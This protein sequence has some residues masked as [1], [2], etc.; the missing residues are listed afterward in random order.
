[1]SKFRA[2]NFGPGDATNARR[3]TWVGYPILPY[4]LNMCQRKNPSNS[5]Q[6][7][8]GQVDFDKKLWILCCLWQKKTAPPIFSTPPGHWV[9]DFINLDV[10]SQRFNRFF[11]R[12]VF[13]WLA[14]SVQSPV[15]KRPAENSKLATK[16]VR[17]CSFAQSCWNN[18]T[19]RED[20]LQVIRTYVSVEICRELRRDLAKNCE[21]LFRSSD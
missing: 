21:I 20:S 10:S 3:P 15:G 12:G 8:Q 16:I 6:S 17:S 4:R 11:G 9:T 14:F 13:S 18:F 5:F 1:M 7:N 19:V 2:A